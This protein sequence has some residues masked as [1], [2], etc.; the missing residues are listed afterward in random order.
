[1]SEDVLVG[2]DVG[3]SAVKAVAI[4]HDGRV[5]GLAEEPYA[6]SVPRPGWAE[7]D[8]D[9]WWRA[10][11]AALGRVPVARRGSRGRCALV[12]LDDDGSIIRPAIL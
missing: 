7:Q 2:L 5:R 3:T 1:M 6:L 10:A 11:K 12:V 4:T 8:P 9:V